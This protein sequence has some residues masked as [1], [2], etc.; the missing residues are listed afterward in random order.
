MI[1]GHADEDEGYK[2]DSKSALREGLSL[3]RVICNMITDRIVSGVHRMKDMAR[4]VRAFQYFNATHGI[5]P[6][7]FYHF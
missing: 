1:A 5:Q 3:A 6:S 2:I 7:K 4:W